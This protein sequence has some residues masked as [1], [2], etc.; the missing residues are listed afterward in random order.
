M[1]CMILVLNI[2]EYKGSGGGGRGL[3]RAVFVV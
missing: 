1:K 3:F 2:D